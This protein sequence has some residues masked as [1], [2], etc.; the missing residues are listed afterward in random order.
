M[1]PETH[2][3]R[4]TLIQVLICIGIIV[5]MIGLLLPA[6]RR[7]R[8]PAMRMSCNHK[9]R[10]IM[11]GL[12]YYADNHH[13]Y[14]TGCFG[15]GELPEERLSWFVSLL[16]Y[17]EQDA[18]SRNFQIELGYEGNRIISSVLIRDFRCPSHGSPTPE[19][20]DPEIT[21]YF[22]SAGLGLDAATRRSDAAGIGYMGYDRE[23]NIA[24]LKDGASNT[25]AVTETRVNLGPWAR[26]GV[27]TL[28]G[29]D[30]EAWPLIGKDRMM[31]GHE[32]GIN[33]AMADGSVRFVNE[34]IDPQVWSAMATIAGGE[35]ISE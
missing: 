5:L 4:M 19:I 30:K 1:M 23:T 26:G 35:K 6:V 13:V 8:E 24:S 27:S 28:K 12:E 9:L 34:S 16:P 11:F 32:G 14:P 10:L 7:V 3:P 31:G 20:K 21:S 33:V 22:A 25:I 15:P 18:L 17:V 29:F 2:R